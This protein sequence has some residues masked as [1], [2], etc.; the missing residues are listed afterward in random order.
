M[1]HEPPFLNAPGERYHDFVVTKYTLIAE[2]KCILR[3]LLHMPSGAQIMHIANDDP[4]NFFCLS[5]KTLPTS[6]NGVAHILEHT[7]LC[8]SKRFPVKDPFFAMNRR[9]LNTFMNALTGSDFTCYPAASQV[10]KDFYNL[11]DVY[12][13]AV[14]HPQLKLLSFLQEGHRLEFSNPSDPKSPLEIKGIVFNEMKGALTSA[15]ARLWH[16]MMHRLVPDLP[17]AFN[18]GGD[19]YDIPNLTYEE[20][21]QF[22]ETYYHPSRCLFFFYGNLPLKQH[23][24]YIQE[25]TLK[26]VQKV[27]PIPPLPQQKRFLTPVHETMR[28]PVSESEEVQ[29]RTILS[30][31][32]LTA[33]LL[34]QDEVLALSVLDSI[35]METDASPLKKAI[36][37]SKL[38]V[39]AD[40]FMDTEMSEIPYVL[41][42]KGCNPANLEQ[43]EQ[44]ILKALEKI[45][46]QGIPS[47]LIE[48]AIHQ[49][50]LARLEISGDHAPFGLTLFMRS[51]LAKQHGA[52]PEYAL[53][54][55]SLFEALIAKVKD[56]SYFPNLISKYL[57]NNFHRVR[58]DM[59]PDPEL[60]SEEIKQEKK[61]LH[62]I[63]ENLTQAQVDKILAQTQQLAAYQKQ[64]EEQSLDCLPKVTLDDV[65]PLVR[66]FS[67]KHI[68]HGH[69]DIFHHDCF[70]NHL[71]YADLIFDLPDLSDDELPYAHLLTSLLPE[72]G[73]GDRDYV[74]NLEYIQAHTG[75]IGAAC[76]LHVQASDPKL[77][78]PCINIRGKA[79][80]RKAE[81]L[82]R[83]IR[84]TALRPRYDEKNRIHELLIQLRDSLRNRLN[85]QGMRYAIQL[86]LSGFT[87]AAHISE[88][89]FGVRYY[90][91]IEKI[92]KDLDNNLPKLV[93]QLLDL[94]ER[95]F[96]FHQPHLV[97]SCSKEML[98]ELVSHDFYGLTNLQSKPFTPWKGEFPLQTISS[99]ARTIASQVAFNA[100]AYKTITYIHPFAPALVVATLLLDN[101]VLHR[102]I[103]EQGGAY[104]CGASYTASTGNFYLHSYRDPHIAKT[105]NTFHEAIDSIAGGHFTVQDL[106]EAKLGIVQQLDTPIAP[107]SRGLTAYSWWRD[108]KSKE[109]RQQFRDRLLALT[110]KEVQHAIEME[111]L[112]KK[113]KGVFVTFSGKEL[114]ERENTA[115]ALEKKSLPIF[116]V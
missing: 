109:M 71:L 82:F 25:K 51:A 83:L 2:L 112:P 73:S 116:S 70:T 55:H 104:G 87:P 93:D 56:P 7:A 74:A 78:K 22:H 57:L 95:L 42:C 49:L 5:F 67:L 14:F 12:L 16:A 75:G 66:D 84:D 77:S 8:G 21:I 47:H 106:E 88:A 4:E 1:V 10:E 33:P 59:H 98:H 108:G 115:L 100:E 23:L 99:Q 61:W 54:I 105:W 38:C 79:I 92:C 28:Y 76:A 13:D 68:R 94:Q 96:S 48:A 86:A 36:L 18:S 35:L 20:L 110:P 39:Q 97:L 89:W 34:A 72:I 24:D 11:L 3:E 90:Q 111:I 80:Y 107:G 31:G 9:S 64:T 27:I 62:G 85:R 43:L 101:K 113:D 65:T 91:T 15:D 17:Y 103:R 52:D 102:K 50:E 29:N 81:P 37:A 53:M 60:S 69:F 45:V 6:S 32:W 41:V 114:L 26:N 63:Q 58:I 19:P 44:T 46:S 30:L 40:A